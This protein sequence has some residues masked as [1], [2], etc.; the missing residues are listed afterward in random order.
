MIRKDWLPYLNG[1]FD[2]PSPKKKE[3]EELAKKTN[4]TVA[5]I[6]PKFI[7]SKRIDGEK[8]EKYAKKYKEKLD[9]FKHVM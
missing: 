8:M 2:G 6:D 4:Q 5:E 3:I 7:A 1:N 9:R